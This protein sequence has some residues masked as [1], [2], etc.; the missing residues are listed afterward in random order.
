MISTLSTFVTKLQRNLW[1]ASLMVLLAFT[2]A[3]LLLYEFTP[4]ARPEVVA[5]MVRYDLAI[6]LIFLTDFFLG[7]FFNTTYSKKQYWKIN[8]L[9]FIS[10][11]PVTSDMAR[12]LRVLRALRAL[13]VISSALDIYFTRRRYLS[14]RKK[15]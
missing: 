15:K 2:G 6:A 13:R 10:S 12:A 5:V 7:L 3:G 1:Y 14:L 4:Y 9:D 11:I 8:W